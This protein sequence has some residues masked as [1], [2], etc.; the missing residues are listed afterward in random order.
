[1]TTPMLLALCSTSFLLPSR[2]VPSVG[3]PSSTPSPVAFESGFDMSDSEL[4]LLLNARGIA[5]DDNVSRDELLDMLQMTPVQVDKNENLLSPAE[6]ER[7]DVFERVAPAVAYIQTSVVSSG[8]S[9]FQWRPTE[10]RAGAGSG[11]V[12]D[13]DGHVITNAHVI[14]G[15]PTAVGLRGDKNERDLPRRVTVTL[16]N[17]PEPLEATVVG[18]ELDKDIAVLKIDPTALAP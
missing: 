17:W 13:A 8:G 3:M 14:T 10:L 18:M 7:V 6:A 2:V 1:M 4:K 12:W 9:P 11:F 5:Y 15:G 16:Q